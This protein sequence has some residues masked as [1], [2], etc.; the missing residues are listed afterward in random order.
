MI[1]LEMARVDSGISGF[2]IIT[3]YLVMVSIELCGRNRDFV[4]SFNCLLQE[5]KNKKKSGSRVYV[6]SIH[7]VFDRCETSQFKIISASFALT[8]PEAGSDASGLQT[9]AKKVPGGWVLNGEK[10]WIGN[11]TFADV[12]VVWARNTETNQVNGFLVEKGTLGFKAEKM[13]NKFAF[14]CVQNA[15]I[16]FTV[17]FAYT[18]P[19]DC[20]LKKGLFHSRFATNAESRLI[21]RRHRQGFTCFSCF[22]RLASYRNR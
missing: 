9:T 17:S 3:K 20:I 14:R 16:T 11:A 2:F 7:L 21:F 19:I 4:T 18:L 1:V 8:E 10:R 12:V 13:E 6:V 5:V 15:H 22:Y